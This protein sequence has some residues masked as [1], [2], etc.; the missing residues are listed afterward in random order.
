MK[1]KAPLIGLV[2]ATTLL[3]IS[4]T[5]IFTHYDDLIIPYITQ[6]QA[7]SDNFEDVIKS[8]APKGSMTSDESLPSKVLEAQKRKIRIVGQFFLKDLPSPQLSGGTGF[9]VNYKSKVLILSARHVLLEPIL[10]IHRI[11]GHYND[12]GIPESD[13]YKY[14]FYG[15]IDED[16]KHIVF[17]IKPVAMGEIGKHQDYVAFEAQRPVTLKTVQLAKDANKGDDVYV[18]GFSPIES[19]Y[20]NTFGNHST[21]LSDIVEY[22][23]K[24]K[25]SAKIEDMPINKNGVKIYYRIRGDVEHGFSGGPVFNTEGEV[26]GMVVEG[27]SNFFYAVSS[28]DLQD[29][30]NSI[31]LK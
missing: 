23:F 20:P 17:P 16:G 1:E 9:P 27:L 28:N 29:F 5:L 24:N 26:I 8:S 6:T 11:V 2:L 19:P 10:K 14:Q 7:F 31:K 13:S 21:A 4:L 3:L 30:L 15:V 25:I 22:S 18:S 12:A